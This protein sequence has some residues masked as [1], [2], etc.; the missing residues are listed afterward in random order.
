MDCIACFSKFGWTYLLTPHHTQ[1]QHT[2]MHAHTTHIQQHPI[3]MSELLFTEHRTHNDCT[4]TEHSPMM[5]T[6]TPNHTHTPNN[7]HTY[8]RNLQYLHVWVT[9]HKAQPHDN[10][11]DAPIP[12]T[13]I[14]IADQTTHTQQQPTCMSKLLFTE[15]RPMT[16]THTPHH[17]PNKTHTT[18]TYL[19]IWVTIHRAQTHDDH[20]HTQPHHNPQPT[21][22]H[23]YT[24]PPPP[25]PNHTQQHLPAHPSYYSLSRALWQ[26][27]RTEGETPGNQS[28]R[29][30]SP[31]SVGSAPRPCGPARPAWFWRGWG[32]RGNF[33]SGSPPRMNMASPVWMDSCSKAMLTLS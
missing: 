17:T 7:T 31:F 3:C 19:H 32:G 22:P 28:R 13:Y 9:S 6:H 15:H 8:N 16:I 25:P 23:T 4:H 12:H 20:T 26:S 14:H 10:Y 18:A 33:R 30:A 2:E 21:T 24:Q 11:T 1:P 5:I 29:T 27:R